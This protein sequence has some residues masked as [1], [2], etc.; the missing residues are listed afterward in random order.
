MLMLTGSG[1]ILLMIVGAL[2]RALC[3]EVPQYIAKADQD[4]QE[5]AQR[6]VVVSQAIELRLGPEG[7]ELFRR[8]IAEVLT[9]Q[10]NEPLHQAIDQ[11]FELTKQTPDD[12][13]GQ[14]L[15]ATFIQAHQQ[16][17]TTP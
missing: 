13:Q 3:T 5:A 9:G 1:I 14:Y 15:V 12:E 16:L 11:R 7:Y 2:I 6:L 10:S 17:G 4:A 8:Y